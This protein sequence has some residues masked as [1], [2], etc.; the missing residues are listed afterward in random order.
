MKTQTITELL[1]GL[2]AALMLTSAPAWAQVESTPVA[3]FPVRVI[4]VPALERVNIDKFT[5]LLEAAVSSK[6]YPTIPR[7]EL[8]SLIQD[9][10]LTSFE[11][12]YDEA[13]Q[14][15]LGRAVA[16]QKAL[17]TSFAGYGDTCLL[18]F[19]FYD[20]KK[21]L[22]EFSTTHEDT[23]DEAGLKRAITESGQKLRESRRSGAV[24]AAP[25]PTAGPPPPP[26]PV[27]PP[28]KSL[29]DA[30]SPKEP[31]KGLGTGGWILIGAGA[32]AVVAGAVVL[33]LV[34]GDEDDEDDPEVSALT[35]RSANLT[36]GF[37]F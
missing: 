30:P 8:R 25:P 15:E 37:R 5:D 1:G 17:T 18:T 11:S 24:A 20:L 26:P 33:F 6:R 22:T 28:S 31:K 14:I 3:V 10:T 36:R 32:A 4:D 23:C 9:Q 16:A 27:T 21:A 29:A 13:C 12:C 7:T 19:K 35:S 34:L 2:G